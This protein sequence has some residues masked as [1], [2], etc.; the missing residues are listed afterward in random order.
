M[1]RLFVC[2]GFAGL[3]QPQKTRGGGRTGST[4]SPR[5]LYLMGK[6]C[7]A[8]HHAAAALH[9]PLLAASAARLLIRMDIVAESSAQVPRASTCERVR[10]ALMMPKTRATSSSGQDVALWPR[11]PR[12]NSWCGHVAICRPGSCSICRVRMSKFLAVTFGRIASRIASCGCYPPP[13]PVRATDQSIWKSGGFL[14]SATEA[15]H[16]DARSLR[17]QKTCSAAM[18][19]FSLIAITCLFSLVGRAPAQ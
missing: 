6:R 7:P 8:G 3:Q 16:A 14:G 5:G 2:I 15:M 12:L 11:Q 1:N 13:P 19:A 10:P 18:H 4:S 17:P 9:A